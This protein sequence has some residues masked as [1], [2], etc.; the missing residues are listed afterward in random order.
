MILEHVLYSALRGTFALVQH[1]RSTREQAVLS[2]FWSWS[3]NEVFLIDSCE[4]FV[5][6]GVH[7]DFGLV[8]CLEFEGGGVG[9]GFAVDIVVFPD[10]DF[11]GFVVGFEDCE[12]GVLHDSYDG[13]PREVFDRGQG[14]GC[15]FVGWAGVRVLKE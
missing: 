9:P 13:M 12:C 8:R 6:L 4:D 11:V 7:E 5:E 2:G 3:G 1:D 10:D 14:C 15:V